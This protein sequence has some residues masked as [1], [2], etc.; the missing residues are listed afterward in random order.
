LE[1]WDREGDASMRGA[2]EFDV[3]AYYGAWWVGVRKNR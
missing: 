3:S 1:A 2:G